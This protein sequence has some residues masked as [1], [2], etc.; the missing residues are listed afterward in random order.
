MRCGI[1]ERIEP[2]IRWHAGGWLVL[3]ESPAEAH[4]GVPRLSLGRIA[5]AGHVCGEPHHERLVAFPAV[6]LE[7]GFTPPR[8][9]SC[10]LE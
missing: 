5:E 10:C 8:T 2:L 9:V 1:R 3:S 7:W 4:S 6:C